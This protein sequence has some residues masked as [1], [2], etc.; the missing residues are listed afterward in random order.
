ME[1]HWGTFAGEWLR[2][3]AAVD[4]AE[5]AAGRARCGWPGATAWTLDAEDAILQLA[6]HLA[7]NHQMAYPGVRGLLDVAL[8][9]RAEKLD[10]PA[11]AGGRAQWRVATAAWLVLSLTAELLGLPGAD[12]AVRRLAPSRRRRALLRRFVD[13]QYVLE[14]RDMTGGPRRLAFQL[15]LVDRPRDAGR[16]VGRTLWPEREWLRARY[17]A[18]GAGVRGR[19]LA[20]VARRENLGAPANPPGP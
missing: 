11:L 9:A 17:G 2:R 1:L 19:H 13:G 10:W 18:A 6:V 15:L 20:R 4:D 3:T 14:G 16:L 8:L 12:Q 5:S 7:V